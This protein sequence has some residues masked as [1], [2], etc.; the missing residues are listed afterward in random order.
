MR[1]VLLIWGPLL[2][3]APFLVRRVVFA[4]VC[5]GNVLVINSMLN[6]LEV[7]M[8]DRHAHLTEGVNKFILGFSVLV[9]DSPVVVVENFTERLLR[10]FAIDL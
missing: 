5:R 7:F 10:L 2:L 4:K 9:L 3:V 8:S 6:V 1:Q